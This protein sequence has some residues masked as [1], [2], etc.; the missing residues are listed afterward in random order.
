MG[1]PIISVIPSNPKLAAHAANLQSMELLL[2]HQEIRASIRRLAK[3][4]VG[5]KYQLSDD[6]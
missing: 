4:V 3:A 1:L 5:K 6:F 2:K